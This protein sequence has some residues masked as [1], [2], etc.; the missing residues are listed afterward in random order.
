[1]HKPPVAETDNNKIA[2]GSHVEVAVIELAQYI[3]EMCAELAVM[4]TGAQM[5]ML[6]YLLKLASAEAYTKCR[7]P[8]TKL[9]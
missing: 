9:H 3:C 5:P 2:D 7:D 4:A 1:M 8:D 6:S